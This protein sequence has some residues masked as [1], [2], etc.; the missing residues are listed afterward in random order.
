M[1]FL[2]LFFGF[3]KNINFELIHLKKQHLH[4][5]SDSLKTIQSNVVFAHMRCMLY[6]SLHLKKNLKLLYK[7]IIFLILNND[8]KS[9]K[10][11]IL[12]CILFNDLTTLDNKWQITLPFS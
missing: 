3:Y 4:H 6:Y 11:A 5:L 8:I 12:K 7:I 9:K 1:I 2:L 10:V